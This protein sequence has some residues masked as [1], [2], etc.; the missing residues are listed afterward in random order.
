MGAG[1]LA[2]HRVSFGDFLATVTRCEHHISL[3][4]FWLE[5]GKLDPGVSPSAP[6]KDQQQLLLGVGRGPSVSTLEAQGPG[7]VLLAAG[8]SPWTISPLPGLRQLLPK[9]ASLVLKQEVSEKTAD[10]S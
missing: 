5:K 1:K 2:A 6:E 9:T 3:V 7:V 4:G 10:R 8:F